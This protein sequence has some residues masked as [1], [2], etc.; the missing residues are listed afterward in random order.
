MQGRP[1]PSFLR[2]VLMDLKYGEYAPPVSDGFIRAIR[3]APAMV[4]PAVVLTIVPRKSSLDVHS[5]DNRPCSFGFMM[6][7]TTYTSLKKRNCQLPLSDR[8]CIMNFI[9]FGT[10][11]YVS[12]LYRKYRFFQQISTNC[13][14]PNNFIAILKSIFRLRNS[15]SA[16]KRVGSTN[17]SC[18]FQVSGSRFY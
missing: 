12:T 13:V 15:D 8:E 2:L 7:N 14:C 11:D 5:D 4:I 18:R 10:V 16:S 17:S 9:A 3:P 6:K 1:I